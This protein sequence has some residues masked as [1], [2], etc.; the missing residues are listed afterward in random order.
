MENN[1]SELKVSELGSAEYRY[2]DFIKDLSFKSIH[3]QG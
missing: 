1:V 3:I 2:I